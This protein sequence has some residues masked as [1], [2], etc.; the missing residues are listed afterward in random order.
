MI[1][2]YYRSEH[3]QTQKYLSDPL[4]GPRDPDMF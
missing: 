4:V 1:C 3:I 2:I